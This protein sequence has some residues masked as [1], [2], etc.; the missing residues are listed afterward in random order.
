MKSYFYL[1][2]IGFLWGSQFIFMHQ[3]V[4]EYPPEI[5]AVGRAIFGAATLAILCLVLK[6]KANKTSWLVYM[7]I[8]LLDA[9]L[10]FVLIASGQ[11]HVDSAIAAVLM[12]TIP[13]ITILLAPLVIKG[14]GLSRW[15]LASVVLGFL[16]VL[17]LFSPQIAGGAD[18]GLA[19]S[20]M[21]LIGASCFGLGML[22]IKRFASDHPIIVAR[23]IL[24][25]SVLQLSLVAAL[26]T[27]I[28]S[29]EYHESGVA[30]IALL[31]IFCTGLVYFLFMALIQLSGPS[32]ASFSN[33]LVPVFGVILGGVLLNEDIAA[34]TVA[35][36]AIILCSV[37]LHQWAQGRES[38][39][40]QASS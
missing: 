13:F 28:G 25:C 3:A 38:R 1:L 9:T 37:A 17:L 16:G 7:M 24:I 35:A 22:I 31:G 2:L 11:Q 8:A 14:E 10:P 33:Y 32:F 34:T 39:Q 6:L 26:T 12:G 18:A 36:L 20:V 27:D 40:A 19:A 5:V 4:A 30:A 15:G 21:I 29:L 23:N